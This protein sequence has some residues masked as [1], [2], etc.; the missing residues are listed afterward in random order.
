[1]ITELV[2]FLKFAQRTPPGAREHW[3][4]WTSRPSRTSRGTDSDPSA[5]P[6]FKAPDSLTVDSKLIPHTVSEFQRSL[7]TGFSRGSDR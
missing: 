6:Q 7:L 2:L 5:V 4:W 3:W 1:M